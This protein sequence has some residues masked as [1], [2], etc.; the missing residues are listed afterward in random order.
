MHFDSSSAISALWLQLT[1]IFYIIDQYAYYF[2]N[3][4]KMQMFD[5]FAWQKTDMINRFIKIVGE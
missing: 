3:W 5:V 2:H 1:F 4:K